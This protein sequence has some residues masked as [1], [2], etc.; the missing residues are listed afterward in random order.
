MFGDLLLLLG[1]IVLNGL[2][3]ATE[4]AVI[5]LRKTR[6]AQLVDMKKKGA[7]AVL[8]LRNQTERFLATV[9]VGITA[10][11]ASAAAYGESSIGIRIA[12]FLEGVPAL[13]SWASPIAFTVTISCIT[14]LS[15]VLGELVPKSLALRSPEPVALLLARPLLWLS[16][17]A[18]PAV[19]LLS[20]S[21]NMLLRF[22]GDET[23]FTEARLSP[24]ELQDLVTEAART[25]GIDTGTADIA[26]RA[27][28]MRELTAED[29]MN[30][31]IRIRALPLDATRAQVLALLNEALP[32]SFPV[33]EGTIDN[34]TGYVAVKELARQ[35][36]SNSNS[37]LEP[38]LRPVLYVPPA[39]SAITLLARMQKEGVP[40][41]VVLDDAGGTKGLVRFEDLLDELVDE[42]HDDSQPASTSVIVEEGGSLLVRADLPVRELN[43]EHGL[44]LPESEDWVTMAGLCLEL[45][46]R[47]PAVGTLLR[48]EDGSVIEIL[49]AT[50]RMI[51][52]VRVRPES[53][54]D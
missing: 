41:A 46:G 51:R 47:I 34:L 15:V 12:R 31:R 13:A 50:P 2:F 45:A 49:D 44:T 48:A 29:V 18:R 11:G 40:M 39:L 9:Q 5:T 6:V 7:P 28:D 42:I 14:F 4:I 3:S 17:L 36:L 8:Y 38:L 43:R 33:F 1:L 37:S 27:L 23:S 21:S 20:K 53:S 32:D 22:F 19:W 26:R 25:G 16:K 35:L 24:D 52:S 10:V 54:T 30:P